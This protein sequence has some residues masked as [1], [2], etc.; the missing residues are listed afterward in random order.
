[1]PNT[2]ISDQDSEIIFINYRSVFEEEKYLPD[3]VQIE[4]GARSLNE[5]LINRSTGSII[6][7]TFSDS[8]F[9]EETF[10]SKS[11]VLEKTFLEKLILL[12]EEFQKPAKKIRIQL[13]SRHLFDIYA[14]HNTRFGEAAQ[15]TTIT[16]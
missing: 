4:I 8:E 14:L 9:V 3:R 5:P 16:K 11:I 7:G 15:H 10:D 13:M 2:E 1:V 12:H 6:D